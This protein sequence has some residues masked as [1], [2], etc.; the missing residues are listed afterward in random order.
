MIAISDVMTGQ[1]DTIYSVLIISVYTFKEEIQCIKIS[2][3][4][5]LYFRGTSYDKNIEL[6]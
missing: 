6:L 1:V 2:T 4:L 5:S 3:A